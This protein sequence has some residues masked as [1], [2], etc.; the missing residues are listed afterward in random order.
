VSNTGSVT[1]AKG[2]ISSTGVTATCTGGKHATGGGE[3]VSA[4][5][6]FGDGGTFPTPTTSGAQPLGWQGFAYNGTQTATITGNI[7]VYAIC[8]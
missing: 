7:T 2:T 8:G 6:G 1:A 5:A 3:D 4:T